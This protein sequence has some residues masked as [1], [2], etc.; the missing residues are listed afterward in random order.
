MN[1]IT[2]YDK[3]FRTFI[4]YEKIMTAIDEVAVKINKDFEG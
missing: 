2:L 1:K 4:P 3:T